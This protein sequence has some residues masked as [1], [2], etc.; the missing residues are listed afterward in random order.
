MSSIKLLLNYAG[1]ALISGAPLCACS[2]S[3]LPSSAQTLSISSSASPSN[4]PPA[5]SAASVT[6]RHVG[7]LLKKDM[8]YADA[9]KAL[10]AQ[11]WMPEKD[12]QCKANVG[13]NEALCKGTP[14]LTVC[15]ICDEIP[16]LSAYSDGGETVTHFT[17]NG[18][19]LTLRASGSI[20]D[21]KISRDDSRLSVTGWQASK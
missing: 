13:A 7:R 9:R 19:R 11:G 20:S 15:R 8:A 16:E 6:T 17:R 18:H 4:V 5:I 2:F 12:A 1:M 14:G 21:W 10:L 3:N